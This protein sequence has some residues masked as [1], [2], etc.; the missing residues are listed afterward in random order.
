FSYNRGAV[1]LEM[2][3]QSREAI[4]AGNAGWT[5]LCAALVPNFRIPMHSYEVKSMHLMAPLNL[6]ASSNINLEE[7]NESFSKA[8][9]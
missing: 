4:D 5:P 1:V 9:F 7:S 2:E 3:G 8:G 6:S